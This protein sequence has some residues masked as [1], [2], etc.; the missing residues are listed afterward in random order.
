MQIYHEII[1]AAGTNLPID[2]QA[3]SAAGKDRLLIV[4]VAP[5]RKA[6]VA[7]YDRKSKSL[8]WEHSTPHLKADQNEITPFLSSPVYRFSR[9][10]ANGNVLVCGDMNR[11]P[12]KIQPGLFAVLDKNGLP[13]LE[14]TVDP[15]PTVGRIGRLN[16]CSKTDTGYLLVGAANGAYWTVLLDNSGQIVDQKIHKAANGLDPWMAENPSFAVRG[17]YI[18]SVSTNNS[19]SEI[20]KID[21]K[22]EVVS[23][24]SIPGQYVLIRSESTAPRTLRLMG[25]LGSDKRSPEFVD[26]SEELV[27]G[28]RLECK[29]ENFVARIALSTDGP[30]I[31]AFGTLIAASFRLQAAALIINPST[32]SQ[33]IVETNDG[34]FDGGTIRAATLSSDN[35]LVFAVPRVSQSRT[36]TGGLTLYTIENFRKD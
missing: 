5:F 35:R 27:V 11:P 7:L 29:T 32:C 13:I 16:F 15:I 10:E 28:A 36:P 2:P 4:G 19:E 12:G 9:M 17:E 14:I 30:E 26:I 31:V 34:T 21:M 6:W 20:I 33:N 1:S 22:G 18:Y 25:W 3:I 8:I 24:L 23:E